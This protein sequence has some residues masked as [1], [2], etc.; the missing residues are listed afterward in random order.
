MDNGKMTIFP[1]LLNSV[2]KFYGTK[3][4][5]THVLSDIDLKVRYGELLLLIGPSGSGKTTLLSI[6]A[7]LLQPTTGEVSLFGKN[8]VICLQRTMQQLRAK[9][10]GFVFQSFNLLNALSVLDNVIM[11]A[12]I[13]G[14]S[15]EDANLKAKQILEQIGV[16]YLRNKKPHQL[17]QGE[18]QRVAIARAFVNEPDLIIAD[19]PTASL[20]SKQ[21]QEII[22][23]LHAYANE[24]NKS[25]IVASHDLRLCEYADRVLRLEDGK[26][27]NIDK[28]YIQM[29]KTAIL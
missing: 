21:G 18:K 8:P 3:D 10:I 1:V 22:Q 13:A 9:R 24:K 19:E 15:K 7:G 14:I 5:Q 2:S 17:S 26:L 11:S 20:E 27:Q 6:I 23:L 4:I 29:S 25:V 16:G 28:K 12:T